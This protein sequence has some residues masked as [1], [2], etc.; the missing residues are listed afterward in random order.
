MIRVDIIDTNKNKIIASVKEQDDLF[1]IPAGTKIYDSGNIDVNGHTSDI[2]YLINRGDITDEGTYA[3]AFCCYGGKEELYRHLIIDSD[4]SKY[5]MRYTD[6]D[7]TQ[8]NPA[9]ELNNTGSYTIQEDTELKQSSI[10]TQKKL[11]NSLENASVDQLISAIVHKVSDNQKTVRVDPDDMSRIENAISQGKEISIPDKEIE[12]IKGIFGKQEKLNESEYIWH[13]ANANF[14]EKQ[15]IGYNN[16]V[17]DINRLLNSPKKAVLLEGVPGTGKTLI[18]NKYKDTVDNG[19][20]T[21]M[22]SFHQNYSYNEFIGGYVADKSG[23][24]SYKDGVFTQFCKKAD[25]DRYNRYYFFIDEVSRGNVEAIFGEIMTALTFRDR[26]IKLASDRSFMI[27]SNVYIVAS[28]NITDKSTKDMDIATLQRF[29]RLEIE[30]QWNIKYINR[31][32]S[33][34]SDENCRAMLE[35]ICDIMV[36][37]NKDIEEDADLGKQYKIGTRA[38][39]FDIVSVDCIKKK[40]ESDLIPSILE[41]TKSSF[42]I[43]DKVERTIKSLQEIIGDD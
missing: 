18:L 32:L 6:T 34:S 17:D 1:I 21:E 33:S 37:F 28:R 40:V 8:I 14:V 38:L 5:D 3:S 23:G 25:S 27:P 7:D 36:E 20:N 39:E 31:I 9:E 4:Y 12:K 11:A 13:G 41:N 43:A 29:E 16:I 26:I 10:E 42:E 19:N 24:F 22:V 30:P 2:E 15:I 35:M